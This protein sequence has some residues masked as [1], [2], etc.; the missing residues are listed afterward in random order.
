[1][2]TDLMDTLYKTNDRDTFL[3]IKALISLDDTLYRV[4]A[5]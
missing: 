5:L 4:R 3:K 2:I 1:M